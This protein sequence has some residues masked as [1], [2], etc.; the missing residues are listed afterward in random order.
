[1]TELPEI[2]VTSGS[3]EPVEQEAAR[4]AI[5]DLWRQDQARAAAETP[6]D[7]WTLAGR[8]EANRSGAWAARARG[9]PNAWRLSGRL[10]AQA[11]SHISIGRGDAK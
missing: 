10:S 1:M 4:R 11:E 3:P 9:G 7:P 5:V 2:C 6:A 8:V